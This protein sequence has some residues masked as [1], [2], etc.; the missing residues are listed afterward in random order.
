MGSDG[1]EKVQA[2]S[3]RDESAEKIAGV[4][5]LDHVRNKTVRERLVLEPVLKKVKRR[6]ECW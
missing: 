4:S 5:R 2:A 6:R 1:K 3:S